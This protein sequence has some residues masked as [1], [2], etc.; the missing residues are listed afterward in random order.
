MSG[1]QGIGRLAMPTPSGV[2]SGLG[3]GLSSGSCCELCC[4][5]CRHEVCVHHLLSL[6]CGV[7]LDVVPGLIVSLSAVMHVPD[8]ASCHLCIHTSPQGSG[9]Q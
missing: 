3:F 4:G 2:V 7:V 5:C 6:A 1:K 8:A 9:Y